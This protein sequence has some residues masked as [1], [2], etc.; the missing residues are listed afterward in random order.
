MALPQPTPLIGMTEP[1]SFVSGSS[2]GY[3]QLLTT[4][5]S[6]LISDLEKILVRVRY[7]L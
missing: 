6:E 5:N 7:A 2:D 4:G 1:S 3:A